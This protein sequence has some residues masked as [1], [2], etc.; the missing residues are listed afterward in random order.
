MGKFWPET[1]DLDCV[2]DAAID[3]PAFFLYDPY[4][5]MFTPC[6]SWSFVWYVCNCVYIEYYLD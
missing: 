2:E 4:M 1:D 6:C 3:Q 5:P